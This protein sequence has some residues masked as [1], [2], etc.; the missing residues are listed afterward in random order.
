MISGKANDKVL[1]EKWE[2]LVRENYKLNGGFDYLNYC[3]VIEGYNHLIADYNVVKCT[4]IEL[5][6]FVD[7]NY[8][9]ELRE[10]GYNIDTTDSLAYVKSINSAMHRSDNLI[11]RMKMKANEI[12]GMIPKEGKK[13]ATFEEIMAGL[14]VCLEFDLPEDLKL[15]R[16]N[17]YKKIIN[18]RNQKHVGNN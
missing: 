11:T 2:E 10:K 5:M 16:F 12:E 9:K 6:F 3:D 8:I 13:A 1:F 4:L 14:T 15:A 17:E 18:E 7:D